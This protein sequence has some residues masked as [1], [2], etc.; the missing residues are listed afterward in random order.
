ML[1]IIHKKKKLVMQMRGKLQQ[2]NFLNLW[3]EGIE[4]YYYLHIFVL[5]FINEV[6]YTTSVNDSEDKYGSN[7]VYSFNVL[8]ILHAFVLHY[9]T[10]SLNK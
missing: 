7:M 2:Q 1:I 10:R 6:I 8:K 5:L 4:K 3:F 9:R